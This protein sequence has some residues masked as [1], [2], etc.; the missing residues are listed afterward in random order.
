LVKSVRYLMYQGDEPLEHYRQSNAETALTSI[1]AKFG[2]SLRSKGDIGQ[3]N[4]APC[5]VFCDTL[6]VLERGNARADHRTGI[7]KMMGVI[8]LQISQNSELELLTT[9][10][11]V[12]SYP[13]RVLAPPDHQA[14]PAGLFELV[15]PPLSQFLAG[16]LGRGF[17]DHPLGEVQDPDQAAG[18]A[19]V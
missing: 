12:Q 2:D 16:I 8:Y 3:I 19:P 6:G 11:V 9:Q 5:K 13:V 14:S 7:L 4:E 17:I 15:L 18:S 1:K 10:G